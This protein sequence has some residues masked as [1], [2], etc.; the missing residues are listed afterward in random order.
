[1]AP[2]NVWRRRRNRG[3]FALK[4]VKC[5]VPAN[6]QIKRAKSANMCTNWQVNHDCRRATDRW[7]QPFLLL[8]AEQQCRML[9]STYD[10]YQYVVHTLRHEIKVGVPWAVVRRTAGPISGGQTGRDTS[11]WPKLRWAGP[12]YGTIGSVRHGLTAKLTRA[13]W[14]DASCCFWL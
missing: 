1:M 8:Q 6:E 12:R 10:A 3:N 4:N 13:V 2:L 14:F 9:K 7:G 11:S 5:Y